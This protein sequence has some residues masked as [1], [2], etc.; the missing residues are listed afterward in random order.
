MVYVTHDQVEAMTMS[1]RVA[2]FSAGQLCQVDEPRR[3]Y[4][5]PSSLFVA[6]FLGE[7]NTLTGK[8]TGRTD[9][10]CSVSLP[11]GQH[12]VATA[13]SGHGEV[14]L[15]VRPEK[16]VLGDAASSCTNRYAATLVEVS[17]LGDQ[18]RLRL[19]AFGRDDFIVKLPNAPGGAMFEQGAAVEIGWRPEDCRAL[20]R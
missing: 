11:D 5:E 6:Q 10:R 1:D 16:I 18:L 20:A 12:V 13:V 14:D 4:E 7:S 15:V 19:A 2:V 17:F 3:L 8:V 9:G